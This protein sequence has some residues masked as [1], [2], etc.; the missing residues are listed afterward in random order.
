MNLP[1]VPFTIEH[2]DWR[3]IVIE[4]R[5]TPNWLECFETIYRRPLALLEVTSLSPERAV[6]PITETGYTSRF[7][8]PDDIDASGGPT[9]YVKAWLDEAASL[10]AWRQREAEA[11]QMSL[12]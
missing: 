11:Q 5:Y 6:L 9:A 1:H 10:P 3:G 4:V 7:L 8:A 2:L 12:F